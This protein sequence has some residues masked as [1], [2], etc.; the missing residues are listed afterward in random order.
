MMSC[1]EVN[2]RVI[3]IPVEMTKKCDCGQKVS[4]PKIISDSWFS[5]VKMLRNVISDRITMLLCSY[6]VSKL[7]IT[8]GMIAE[9]DHSSFKGQRN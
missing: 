5:A 1:S 9:E 8:L 2:L 4:R 3:C 7:E 6:M